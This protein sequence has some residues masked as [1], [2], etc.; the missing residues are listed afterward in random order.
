MKSIELKGAVRKS[1]G[2]KDSKKLRREAK[3]PC[4]LYG[5]K[6]NIHFSLEKQSL[7]KLVYTPNVYLVDLEIDGAKHRAILKDLQFHPVTEEILHIDFLEVFED[8]KVE[9]SIPVMLKGLAAGVKAGGKLQVLNRKL[10]VEALPKDLPDT[11]D[12]DITNLA[13]GKSIKVGDV[14]FE[15]IEMLNAKNTVIASVK[16]TRAAKGAAADAEEE[17]GEETAEEGATSEE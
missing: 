1:I 14:S 13:L 4:V 7:K 11:L 16:L 12:I 3:T 6:E 2:K 15:N 9:I 8:K 17:E 5:G 10:K